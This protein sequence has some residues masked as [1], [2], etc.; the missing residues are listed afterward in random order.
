MDD[1]RKN[2]IF[3]RTRFEISKGNQ[4]DN[5]LMNLVKLDKVG[6]K[7]KYIIN[8]YLMYWLIL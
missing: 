2:K 8:K 6:N 4:D 3:R 7:R 1:S 5:E